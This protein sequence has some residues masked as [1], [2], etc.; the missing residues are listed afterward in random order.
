MAALR[1]GEPERDLGFAHRQPGVRLFYP[2]RRLTKREEAKPAPS[3]DRVQA[4]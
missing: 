3:F 2:I 4:A 1:G